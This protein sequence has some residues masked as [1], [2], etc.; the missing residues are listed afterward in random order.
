MQTIVRGVVLLCFFAPFV[1][2]QAQPT[3]MQVYQDLA[4]RCLAAAPDTA[5]VFRI[6]APVDRPYLREALS[7]LWQQEGRTLYLADS[8]SQV[9]APVPPRLSLTVED[10]RVHYAHARRKKLTRTVTLAVRYALTGPDGQLLQEA[11][12]SDTF[13]DTIRRS[14]REKLESL[15]YPETQGND[16]GG[17]WVRRFLEPAVLATAT[18]VAVYLFF[19]LRSDSGSSTP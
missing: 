14:E 2:A 9:T 1:A 13:T 11:G 10:S 12:C 3:N 15:A 7:E 4:V 8:S 19:S 17:G 5:Q 6:E 18:V 16:P